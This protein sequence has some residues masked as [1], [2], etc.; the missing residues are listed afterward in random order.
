MLGDYELLKKLGQGGMGTSTK[1][2][3]RS[4]NASWAQGAAEE[5]PV[6]SGG[7]RALEREMEAVGR[8]D[9]P[10]IVRAMDAPKW[11]AFGFS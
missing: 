10:N 7:G 3:T 8:L 5:S 1:C 4:S 11:P 9:H 6:Q 2:G